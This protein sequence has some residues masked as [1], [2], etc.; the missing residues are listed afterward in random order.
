MGCAGSRG[1]ADVI[2]VWDILVLDIAQTRPYRTKLQSPETPKKI[3][4]PKSWKH[5]KPITGEQLK[6]LREE[7]WDTAPHYGGSKGFMKIWNALKAA[8]ETS[9]LAFAKTLVDSAG[10]IVEKS[11]LTVCYDETGAKYELPNYV[12]SEP[13][14]LIRDSGKKRET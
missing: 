14:N 3:T 11:D 4:K 2:S 1:T 7:F 8:A 5:T 12:L 10:I 13:T 9:D 6:E